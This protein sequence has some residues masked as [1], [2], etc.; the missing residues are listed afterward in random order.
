VTIKDIYG[1]GLNI[2]NLVN[3]FY[4]NILHRAPDPGGLAYY[5]GHITSQA[6]SIGQMLAELSD[7]PEN[8]AQ[9][10][11]KIANGISYSPYYPASPD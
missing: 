4:Q 1:T 7:S 9:V 10:A 2:N 5:A 11:S 3:G 8:Y 6:K